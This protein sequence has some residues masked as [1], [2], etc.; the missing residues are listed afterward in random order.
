MDLARLNDLGKS[1]FIISPTSNGGRKNKTE[2]LGC[3]KGFKKRNRIFTDENIGDEMYLGQIILDKFFDAIQQESLEKL[4][5][6][7]CKQRFEALKHLYAEQY[8]L[9]PSGIL[10]YLLR[11]KAKALVK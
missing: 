6:L 5:N 1:I 3:F 8:G 4:G 7:D 2:K 9:E 11:K 10:L